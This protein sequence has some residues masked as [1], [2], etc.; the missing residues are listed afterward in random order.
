MGQNRKVIKDVLHLVRNSYLMRI[1]D[2]YKIRR[3]RPH[4]LSCKEKFNALIDDDDLRTLCTLSEIGL[5]S[6][7]ILY[8][9]T[10]VNTDE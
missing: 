7:A 8:D 4:L 6:L 5:Q 10:S 2:I 3:N 1:K 9:F